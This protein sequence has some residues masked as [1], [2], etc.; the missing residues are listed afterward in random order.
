MAIIVFMLIHSIRINTFNYN[1]PFL[2]NVMIHYICISFKCRSLHMDQQINPLDT[3][4]ELTVIHLAINTW[5]DIF[6][7]TPKLRVLQWVSISWLSHL[8]GQ[9]MDLLLHIQ[10]CYEIYQSLLLVLIVKTV[11][12]VPITRFNMSTFWMPPITSLLWRSTDSP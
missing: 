5:K 6:Q 4:W 11:W 7:V 12:K 8:S 10:P 1:E 2:I 9:R 3:P